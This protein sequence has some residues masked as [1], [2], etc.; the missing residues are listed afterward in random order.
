M[1]LCQLTVHK[2]LSTIPQKMWTTLWIMWKTLDN[3]RFSKKC[4][5]R[6]NAYMHEYSV[7]KIIMRAAENNYFFN[8]S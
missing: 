8:R 2:K 1:F 4:H 6:I 5:F 3:A 7:S